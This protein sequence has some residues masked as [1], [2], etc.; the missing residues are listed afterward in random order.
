MKNIIIGTAGHIDHGKTTLI[1]AITGRETDR[2]AE[3][4]ERGISIE[5]GFTYFDLPSGRRAGII[6]VPGHEKF[7]KNMLAGIIGIDIVVL[8]VAADEGI[9]PQTKEHF[10]ILDLLNISKGIVVIT[11]SDMV[12]EEWLGLVTEDIEEFVEGTFLENSPIIPVSSTQKIGIDKVIKSIDE[13]T[14][15]V[16]EHDL[17]EMPRLPVDRVF[18]ITGFGTIV[19]G[20]LISGKFKKGQEVQI[21]P[22][23]KVGRIRSIQVH[24]QDTDIAFAGQRVALNLAGLKKSDIQRGNVISYVNSMKDT[25]MIDVKLKLIKDAQRIIENR[26]RV[27][28]YIGTKEVLCRVVLL[29]KE[30]LTPGE[31]CYAQLRLEESIV[32][33]RGDRFII[34]FYSPMITIG[35]GEVIEPNPPKR[36]RFKEDVIEEL[37][38]KEKG[39]NIDV[40]RKIIQEK[41][42]LFPSTLEL[43]K[44]AV[45]PEQRVRKIV[46]ELSNNGDVIKFELTN[47]IHAIDKK[48]YQM[49]TFKI[50]DYL[51]EYHKINPLRSGIIKEEIRSRFLSTIK[52]KLAD[53]FI[54]KLIAEKVI[55]QNNETISLYDFQIQ[56]SSEQKEIKNYIEELFKSSKFNILKRQE[57]YDNL[58]YENNNIEKV[59]S[60]LIDEGILIKIKED[61]IIHNDSY[62]RCIKLVTQ[63]IKTNQ[64]ITLSEFR[65][66]IGSSR[67][68]AMA[69]LEYLDNKKITIRKGNKRLLF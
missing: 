60:A 21:F 69:I 11:K 46:N 38:V 26:T 48:Y 67:K 51:K 47:T 65:D 13:M 28:M 41:S 36:K 59:I 2:L 37:K 55:K 14:K 53:N 16:E 61:M 33:K 56:Y 20:T 27:R 8:V 15:E 44:I 34:R 18:T 64:A 29:D 45:I 6:D 10:S 42:K 30:T 52:P 39:D 3:E 25:M 24:E 1:K 31:T 9:M 68:Y 7:I 35:G 17:E 19:T 63:H 58:K 32:A 49:I 4:K 12:D 62:Q 23:D 57:I 50:I 43:S 66:M 40:I 54:N 22:T 5:L